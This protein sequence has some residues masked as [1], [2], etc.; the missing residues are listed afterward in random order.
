MV[1]KRFSRSNLGFRLLVA[2]NS[3]NSDSDSNFG[4]GCLIRFRVFKNLLQIPAL[5]HWTCSLFQSPKVSQ[6]LLAYIGNSFILFLYSK[7]NFNACGPKFLN[8]YFI[9][10]N[11]VSKFKTIYMLDLSKKF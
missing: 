6:F 11:M 3:S 8:N 9:I 1:K 5:D 2:Q 4:F 7:V 10:F